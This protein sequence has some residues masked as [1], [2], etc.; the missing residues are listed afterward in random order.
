M[1]N[2]YRGN[3]GSNVRSEKLVLLM[4]DHYHSYM[5]NIAEDL[6]QNNN[7]KAKEYS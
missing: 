4:L 1:E 7:E 3:R 5:S 6:C 2:P